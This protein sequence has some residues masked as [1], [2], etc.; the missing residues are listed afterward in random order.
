MWIEIATRKDEASHPSTFLIFKRGRKMR[1]KMIKFRNKILEEYSIDPETAVITNSKGEVQETKII[2]R[3]PY[4]KGMAV[5]KIQVHTKYGYKPGY[6]IH[7]LDENKMNNSLP[8]LVYLTR[9]EHT[10]IHSKGRQFS[11]ETKQKLSAA[12]KGKRYKCINNGIKQRLIPFDEE[13]PEGFVRGR[14]KF[15]EEHK[16]KMSAAMKGKN[17]GKMWINNGLE[18]RFVPFDEEIP[19]GFVRGRLK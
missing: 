18:Q 5:H 13:I 12:R 11:P 1:L 9:N 17:K 6:D 15:S 19:E 4:F 2:G 3:R 14:I 10:M 7:H 8:N 16:Q